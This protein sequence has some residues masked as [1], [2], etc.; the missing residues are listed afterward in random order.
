M[1]TMAHIHDSL[2]TYTQT[3]HSTQLL[4]TQLYRTTSHCEYILSICLLSQSINTLWYRCLF[5]SFIT[6]TLTQ[7][8]QV[9]ARLFAQTLLSWLEKVLYWVVIIIT[10]IRRENKGEDSLLL[11]VLLLFDWRSS[12]HYFQY[13]CNRPTTQ[14]SVSMFIVDTTCHYNYPVA[15]SSLNFHGSLY[16]LFATLSAIYFYL[17]IATIINNNYHLT[18]YM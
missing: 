12:R 14:L 18:Y 3:Y 7:G 5:I 2:I 6:L 4:V 10:V 1:T 11:L 9:I 8:A 17:I 13:S 15:V 16:H